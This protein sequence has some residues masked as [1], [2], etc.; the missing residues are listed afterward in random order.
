[1]HNLPL[2][3]FVYLY[4]T[5][6][7]R[8][9]RHVRY[10]FIC[11]FPSK[12]RLI[13]NFLHSSMRGCDILRGSFACFVFRTV[14]ITGKPPALRCPKADVQ[15]ELWPRSTDSS[16]IIYSEVQKSIVRHI[17]KTAHSKLSISRIKRVFPPAAKN[18]VLTQEYTTGRG[19]SH[20]EYMIGNCREGKNESGSIM[21]KLNAHDKTQRFSEWNF[22]DRL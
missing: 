9:S 1:M 18:A 5:A 15:K 12:A 21:N 19:K 17:G 7:S 22:R 10:I 20:I 8:R 4:N 2:T 11:Q 16:Y 13:N 3:N 6:A 14:A